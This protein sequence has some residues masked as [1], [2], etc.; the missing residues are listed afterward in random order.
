MNANASIAIHSD[1]CPPS[2]SCSEI[3][4]MFEQ[5]NTLHSLHALKF[6]STSYALQL[7]LGPPLLEALQTSVGHHNGPRKKNKTVDLRWC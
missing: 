1:P 4:G 2:H 6:T 3:Q 7:V 5:Q